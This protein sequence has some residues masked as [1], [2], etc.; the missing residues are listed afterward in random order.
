MNGF[1]DDVGTFILR[2]IDFAAGGVES[3][4]KAAC[5]E[6]MRKQ[7]IYMNGIILTPDANSKSLELKQE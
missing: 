2:G 4:S 1:I 3:L 5:V 6:N 7:S